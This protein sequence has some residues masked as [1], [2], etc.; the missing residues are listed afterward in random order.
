[1]VNDVKDGGYKASYAAENVGAGYDS[2]ESAIKRWQASPGHNKNLLIPEITE[3]GIAVAY[4]PESRYKTY[5]A[6]VMAAPL[7]IA[8]AD[9]PTGDGQTWVQATR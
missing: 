5:W 2:L 9:Q 8:L 7:K 6:L 4:A 1:M 3:M